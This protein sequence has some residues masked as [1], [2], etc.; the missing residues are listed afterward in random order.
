MRSRTFILDALS[1][2]FTAHKT[3]TSSYIVHAAMHASIRSPVSA[4]QQF[5]FTFCFSRLFFF[6]TFFSRLF[7]RDFFS[8]CGLRDVRHVHN[9]ASIQKLTMLGKAIEV[10]FIIV[11]ALLHQ[12]DA[13]LPRYIPVLQQSCVERDDLIERYFQLGLQYWEILAFL[14]LSHGIVLSLRQ[15]KRILARRGLRRRNNTSDVDTVLKAVETELNGSGR[16]VG[17]RGMWQRLQQDHNLVIGKFIEF[18]F[19][20]KIIKKNCS[21]PIIVK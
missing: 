1:S 7:F 14:L 3:H 21:Y 18:P 20:L 5:H 15:L 17:Y 8:H 19:E 13:V 16:I 2:I 12:S 11:I 4:I 6:A 9:M 10:P